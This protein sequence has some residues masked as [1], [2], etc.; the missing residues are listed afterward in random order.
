[1]RIMALDYGSKTVG[2]ALTD[3]L[4]L[5][6]QPLETVTR[7]QE[8]KLRKTCRRIEEIARTYEVERIVVGLPLNMDGTPSERSRASEAFAEMIGRRTGLPVFLQDERLTT[9]EADE[10][11]RESGVRPEERK[12]VIDRIAASF[13]L[14]DYLETVKKQEGSK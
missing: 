2:V 12:A 14:R 1:M 6:V 3:A 11:L 4:G 13:I 8:N 9:V 5:T 10:V 7:D